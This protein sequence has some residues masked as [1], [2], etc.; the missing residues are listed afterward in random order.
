MHGCGNCAAV[1]TKKNS[2]LSDRVLIGILK[3]LKCGREERGIVVK[4]HRTQLSAIAVIENHG[5][6]CRPCGKEIVCADRFAV[7]LFGGG[8][9][10]GDDGDTRAQGQ[11]VNG[12]FFLEQTADD[13]QHT[14]TD[15]VAVGH[16]CESVQKPDAEHQQC[17]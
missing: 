8:V 14:V 15:L 16:Q 6:V 5:V 10:A 13:T 1:C 7:L 9:V 17:R 12:A 3:I 4:D 11:R 2:I